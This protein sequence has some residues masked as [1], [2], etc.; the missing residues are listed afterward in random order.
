MPR[1]IKLLLLTASPGDQARLDIPR[2]TQEIRTRGGPALRLET[3]HCVTPEVVEEEVRRERPDIVQITT[4][5]SPRGFMMVETD[6]QG[7]DLLAGRLVQ[8]FAG[9]DSVSLG[10]STCWRFSGS[11]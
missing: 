10:G 4:H 1:T 8:L 9:V 2:E 6:R 3:R 7:R 5:G 11:T